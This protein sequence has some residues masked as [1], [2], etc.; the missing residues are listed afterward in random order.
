MIRLVSSGTDTVRIEVDEHVGIITFTRPERRNALHDEM[1]APMMDAIE[2]FAADPEVGCVVITGDGSAFCA[3]GDVR[4]GSGRRA[5]G[6]RPSPE[7]RAS[8]LAAHGRLSVVLHEAPI[9]TIAAVNGPAVG[10]GMSIALACDLRIAAASARFVGGWA[11]LGFSGDFGGA[12]LLSRRVGPSKAFELLATNATVGA[13]EALRL[14]MVDRVEADD[15][16]D[17]AW[18]EWAASIASGPRAAIASMKANVLD[19]ERLSLGDADGRELAD[20]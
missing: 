19:A 14:R 17:Q 4:D 3:G 6:S 20:G 16:F 18:R 10:A 1:Y 12:W 8:N 11:R 7:E 9:P 5:D 13:Q 2:N 15:Q